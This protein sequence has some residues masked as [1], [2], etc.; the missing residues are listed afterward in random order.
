MTYTSYAL[1]GLAG[2]YLI[3]LL[4]LCGR[5]RLG[6]AIVKATARFINNTWSLFLIPIFFIIII[7]AFICYWVF[8]AAYIFSIGQIGP[9]D[10]P[11]QFLSTVKWEDKTRYIFLYHLFGLLWVNAFIIG[12]A[13]FIIA[14][15]CCVWYFSHQGDTGGKGSI[16]TGIKWIFRYHLGSIAFGSC[17]I[18]IV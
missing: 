15:A 4:C 17:I 3:I 10:A 8:T 9:R 5:I 2:V 11:L 7:G 6:V 1:W 18:A 13:Q 12:C 14:A 16:S